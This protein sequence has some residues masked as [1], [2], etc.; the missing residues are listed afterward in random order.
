MRV[1]GVPFFRPQI[2]EGEIAEVVGCMRNGWL[3]TGAKVAQFE[4]EFAEF[5]GGG[6]EAIAVNSATAAMH[7]ALESHEDR[8]CSGPHRA[9]PGSRPA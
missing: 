5:I 1:N 7:L 3:T 2:G 8:R 6:V 4:A 9:T